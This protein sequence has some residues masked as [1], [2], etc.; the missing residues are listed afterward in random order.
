MHLTAQRPARLYRALSL[1]LGLAAGSTLAAPAPALPAK[2]ERAMA[3]DAEHW[4]VLGKR[5]VDLVDTRGKTLAH[6]D[7]R[8]KQIDLRRTGE[9]ALAV[10]FDADK[11]QAQVLQVL[12]EPP[13]LRPET[14]LPATR[15]AVDSLCLYRDV[16]GLDSVFLV[17][18]DGRTE[19]WL[20]GGPTPLLLRELALPP[21]SEHCRV[22]D[23]T[24][25]LYASETDFGVWAYPA[26]P[27][28]AAGRQL[29]GRLVAGGPAALAVVPDGVATLAAD[30]KALTTF[31]QTRGRWQVPATS[32]LKSPA[33]PKQLAPFAAGGSPGLLLHAAADGRWRR[34]DLGHL[35]PAAASAELPV[36]TARV[37]TDPVA[38]YGDAADD[39]AIWIHPQ[40]PSQSMV[41]ATN[42]KRGLLRYDLQGKERQFL[43]VGRVNNVD[44]RQNLAIDG[45]RYD[46]AVATQRDDNSLVIFSI[47][48]D[49]QVS[50]ASRIATDLQ[51]IY[52]M[53]LYRP[54]GGGLEVFA[55]NKAG[56]FRQ[57]RLGLQQGHFTGQ[58]LRRFKLASQPEG[59]VV[60]DLTGR[61]FIGEE[62]RGIWVTTADAE[63]ATTLHLVLPVGPRLA[64][65]VEG[66]ALYR[67]TGGNY[68]IASSQGN[69]S[70]V[71]LDAEPPYRYRGA[72]RIGINIAAGIDGTSETDGIEATPV[73]LGPPFERG[74]LVVQ[75]GYKRLPEGPQNFKY[76]A[77]QDIAELLGLQ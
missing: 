9:G 73:N 17:G 12:L 68:L 56:E 48:A 60:D 63:P 44:L 35:R 71:V 59:C 31:R 45:Q 75:D 18:K 14:P 2:A 21:R 51:E 64:A 25:T 41:L 67:G 7:V 8:A 5:G 70:Y 34:L 77:W 50:E 26:A 52:G 65:D 66:L 15:Y 42:K 11:Q 16:Q 13:A 39:P 3:V 20:L 54:A 4:L 76:V 27:E 36:L 24:H 53:C 61:L 55:N 33:D 46:L 43:A 72:F 30:G 23:A 57:Y 19:H 22:D 28:G 69:N 49:G 58:L 74:M 62:K 1:L 29:V 37:Q 47:D 32:I 40:D 10:V 38:Q 6:L